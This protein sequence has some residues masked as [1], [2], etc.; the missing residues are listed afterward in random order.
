MEEIINLTSELGDPEEM[1]G[2]DMDLLAGTFMAGVYLDKFFFTPFGHFLKLI[3]PLY[4]LPYEIE[5]EYDDYISASDDIAD[6]DIAF[7]AP[8]SSYTL[9]DIGLQCFD[10][11]KTD[12]N[13]FPAHEILSFEQMKETIF[14]SDDALEVFLL[15]GRHLSSLRE[16]D[17]HM[18]EEI[19]TFRVRDAADKTMWA[20]VQ[21]PD[22]ATLDHLFMEIAECFLLDEDTS[23]V[24]YHDKIENRFAEYTPISPIPK[25]GAKTPQNKSTQEELR[26]LDFTHQPHMLMLIAETNDDLGFGG[27]KPTPSRLQIELLHKKPPEGG[28]EYPRISRESKALEEQRLSLMDSWLDFDEDED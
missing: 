15:V 8:C 16:E 10:I 24:V 9:T 3:R 6:S 1:D 12:T 13:Y 11:D 23:Y 26:S 28:A 17:E 4:I 7:Y 14:S 2:M 20:H 21:V 25:R 5:S 19:Y 22:D 27:M 18:P